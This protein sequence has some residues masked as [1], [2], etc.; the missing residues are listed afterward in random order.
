MTAIEEV[1]WGDVLFAIDFS[2]DYLCLYFCLRLQRQPIHV[3]YL[4]IGAAIGAAFGV[5]NVAYSPMFKGIFGILLT[6]SAAFLC[7][8]F[9]MFQSRRKPLRI[10]MTLPLFF[11]SEAALGGIMTASYH[12]LGGK[13]GKESTAVNE[14]HTTFGF[15][16]LVGTFLFALVLLFFFYRMIS[17]KRGEEVANET[18]RLF[19]NYNGHTAIFPCFFDS[20]NLAREPISGEAVIVLPKE[21]TQALGIEE[22]LLLG[23]R[24]P[25]SRLIPMQT[26]TG[27]TL[28]W[29]ILPKEAYLLFGQ[30]KQYISAYLVF[31]RMGKEGMAILPQCDRFMTFSY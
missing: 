7:C 3:G 20:G 14:P 4:C 19:I 31:M 23:G 13:L 6:I 15:S 5:L 25:G 10:L 28:S 16:V 24:I 11:V 9:A 30:R 27:S 8:Y 17:L 2:M 21:A 1:V 29:G 26:V 18:V 22:P 12:W